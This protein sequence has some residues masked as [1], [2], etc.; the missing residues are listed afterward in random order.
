MWYLDPA[1]TYGHGRKNSL[2][3]SVSL[4]GETFPGP[5]T[6]VVLSRDKKTFLD[7]FLTWWY[8]FFNLSVKSMLYDTWNSFLFDSS[9]RG[10]SQW[11]HRILKKTK[12]PGENNIYIYLSLCLS[13]LPQYEGQGLSSLPT[14]TADQCKRGLRHYG[15]KWWVTHNAPG[16]WIIWFRFQ[17]L[18]N[19]WQH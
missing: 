19:A 16:L 1:C 3:I 12:K 14:P 13:W 15:M 10:Y 7:I 17:M 11:L 8:K 9:L 4:F 6:F 18:P 2:W 5:F